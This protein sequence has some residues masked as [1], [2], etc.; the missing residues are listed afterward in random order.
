[1]PHPVP[2]HDQFTPVGAG[3]VAVTLIDC[4]I[5]TPRRRG[6]TETVMPMIAIESVAVAVCDLESRTVKPTDLV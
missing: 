1:M 3:V 4:E 2:T 6:E 5:G